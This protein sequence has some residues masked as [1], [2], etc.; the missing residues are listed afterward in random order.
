MN[1]NFYHIR[2]AMPAAVDAVV[3]PLLQKCLETGSR[4]IHVMCA[5]D[6]HCQRLSDWLWSHQADAFLPHVHMAAPEA[7]A[8]PVLVGTSLPEMSD[9]LLLLNTATPDVIQDVQQRFPGLQKCMCLF[10]DQGTHTAQA[11]Q[12][13]KTLQAQSGNLAYYVQEKEGWQRKA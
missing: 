5:S 7:A 9:I 12:A 2:S 10:D 3:P 11:R 8:T 1:A 4:R 13:W 6:E